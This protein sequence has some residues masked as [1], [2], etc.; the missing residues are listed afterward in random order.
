M[1]WEEKKKVSAGGRERE[2][3]MFLVFLNMSTMVS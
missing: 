3:D 2:S 1:V